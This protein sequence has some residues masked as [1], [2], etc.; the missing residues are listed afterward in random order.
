MTKPG[1]DNA[2][3]LIKVLAGLGKTDVYANFDSG[4]G[5]GY[6]TRRA[7]LSKEVVNHHVAGDQPIAIYPV[8][9]DQTRIAVLDFDNHDNALSFEELA[10]QVLPVFHEL[11]AIGLRPMTFRSGGGAGIHIWLVWQEWQNARNARRF[12]T[13][14]LLHHGMK[15]GTRGLQ[16]DELEIYPK[17]DRVEGDAVGSAIALPLARQSVPLDNM[18]NPIG[19]RAQWRWSLDGIFSP[20]LKKE[21]DEPNGADRRSPSSENV[22]SLNEVLEGD[23]G[24]AQAALRHLPA[25]D[26]EPWIQIGFILKRSFSEKGFAIWDAWSANRSQ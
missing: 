23:I 7:V 24:E 2:E 14:I 18:L 4:A 9:S 17:Q 25:D 8:V 16:S 10:A 1:A 26:Y 19:D 15:L 6:R 5:R 12:L 11:V 13:R 21:S 20:D 22:S 3:A